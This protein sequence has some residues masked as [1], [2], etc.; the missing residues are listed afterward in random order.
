[1]TTK[2]AVAS[3]RGF[4]PTSSHHQH[5]SWTDDRERSCGLGCGSGR[6]DPI[7]FCPFSR[8]PVLPSDLWE[9]E[10]SGV[11]GGPAPLLLFKVVLLCPGRLA[12]AFWS[13]AAP[14]A[15]VPSRSWCGGSPGPFRRARGLRAF[16]GTPG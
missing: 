4:S 12:S 1:M 16:R 14:G 7:C 11:G 10:R 9:R 8:S 15:A 2:I 5:T 6:R 3:T 13:L